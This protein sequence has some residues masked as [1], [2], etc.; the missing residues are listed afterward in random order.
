MDRICL[1]CGRSLRR[2]R[3]EEGKAARLCCDDCRSLLDLA[4]RAEEAARPGRLKTLR[5]GRKIFA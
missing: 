5:F 2:V 4:D 3:T 1:V